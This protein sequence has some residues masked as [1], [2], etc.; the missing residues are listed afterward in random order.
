VRNRQYPHMPAHQGNGSAR[1]LPASEMEFQ[2][3]S[4]GSGRETVLVSDKVDRRLPVDS[5]AEE[6]NLCS[7]PIR[8]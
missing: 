3:E 8:F 1:F 6:Y 2:A 7:E 5:V 4:S